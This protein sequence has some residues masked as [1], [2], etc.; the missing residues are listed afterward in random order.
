MNVPRIVRRMVQRLRDRV[1]LMVSRGVIRV[2][3][4]GVRLQ[5]LQLALLPGELRDQV[6]RFQEYGFTSFPHPGAEAVAVFIGG[7]RDHGLVIACDDR[8]HRP[9]GL[10]AG[11]VMVYA[12]F[13]QFL[14][15]DDQGRLIISAPKGIVIETPERVDIKGK[16]IKNHA[17]E[18]FQFGAFGFGQRWVY[19]PNLT[20]WQ[21]TDYVQEPA[22]T[23]PV[24]ILPTISATVSAPEIP[25]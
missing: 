16:I 4:D 17:E 18:V 24:Q 10:N 9:R 23:P 6:E 20:Q 2:I 1:M 5:E 22:P 15:L 8:R 7:N 13:G 25:G 12:S 21:R 3:N 19:D 11:E 14:R